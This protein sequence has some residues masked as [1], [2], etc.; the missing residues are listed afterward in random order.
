MLVASLGTPFE[1]QT[2]GTIL[3]I[4]DVSTKPYQVDR[5]LMHLKLAGKL[6]GVRG[7]IFG[8]MLDCVQ[9]ALQDYTLPEVVVRVVGDLNVPVAYGIPSGHVL[10]QNITLPLGVSAVLNVGDSGVNLEIIEPA[11]ST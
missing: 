3:F 10:R 4:E 1:I 5:M 6:T 9:S 2:S 11:T 7:I 8:E